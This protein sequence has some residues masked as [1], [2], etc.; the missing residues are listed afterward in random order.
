MKEDIKYFLELER[1][2]NLF[3][4]KIDD[5]F[6]WEYIRFGCYHLIEDTL[7][8]NQKSQLCKNNLKKELKSLIKLIPFDITFCKEKKDILVLSH[9]R[10]S[11]DENGF[12]NCIYTDT[13]MSEL[14]YS[15]VNFEIVRENTV[16]LLPTV[17]NRYYDIFTFFNYVIQKRILKKK[18][19]IKIERK[20]KTLKQLIDDYYNIS[21]SLCDLNKIITDS[22][23][24]RRTHIK[25]YRNILKQ[26]DPKMIVE[27]V[28]YNNYCMVANEVAKQMGIPI[29]E[30][31]HGMIGNQHIAYNCFD[32]CFKFF[33]DYFF[34][35]SKLWIP[36][37]FPLDYRKIK[38]VGFPYLELQKKKSTE[39]INLFYN[40]N[41][42][43]LVISQWSRNQFY[44]DF[45]EE[46]LKKTN[47]QYNIILKI[48]PEDKIDQKYDK[49]LNIEN[50]KIISDELN[51][52]D[53]FRVADIQIGS[54]STGLCEGLIFGLNTF[55]FNDR[56]DEFIQGLIDKHIF[57]EI[58]SVN[59][60]LDIID[61]ECGILDIDEIW[62]VNSKQNIINEITN[63]M[64]KCYG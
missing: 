41:R 39:I 21:I 24:Y 55:V 64:V 54:Y 3:E 15:F 60:F 57:K 36:K 62:V 49:L 58:K 12:F 17:G 6:Y 47:N 61:T 13:F 28:S 44:I 11:K 19:S 63:I 38:F 27:V 50:I 29:I 31:Q 2:Y 16:E 26:I 59:E 37:K 1:K 32:S 10:K 51:I 52:Y 42:T 45:T 20:T 7:S 30:I 5:M 40:D 53:C 34:A 48:H 4:D 46:L 33:P 8:N 23:F 22:F 25:K 35:F 56:D 43:I 14:P 18:Y 9:Y